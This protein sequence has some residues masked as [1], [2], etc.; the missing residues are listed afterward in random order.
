MV[1]E[2][3][4]PSPY[5]LYEEL[6]GDKIIV[7][8]TQGSVIGQTESTLPPP[9]TLTFNPLTDE[10]TS[11]DG[12]LYEGSLYYKKSIG[13]TP[14]KLRYYDG[15]EWKDI[16]SS[17]KL[18]AYATSARPVC[19]STLL[20]TM[21]YDST[22]N[23]PYVCIVES[24]NYKF[25]KFIMD[26]SLS[27][28]GSA[29]TVSDCGDEGGVLYSATSG[30]FC[31]F[32]LNNCPSGWTQVSNWQRYSTASWGGDSCGQNTSSGPIIFSDVA[33]NQTSSTETKVNGSCNGSCVNGIWNSRCP[34]CYACNWWMD[35]L[36]I[37]NTKNPSGNRLE[38][39]CK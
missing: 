6:R 32:G 28:P 33:A 8:D 14:G 34:E 15:S 18:D 12:T 17:N 23:M 4:Y 37:V 30:T 24:G 3:Y 7:G 22:E 39:G 16:S 10:P 21:I 11:S 26:K 13:A 36:T 9:G 27:Y 29:K 31:K 35:Y 20:G 25:R 38:I 5:G 1:W 19:N 2:T